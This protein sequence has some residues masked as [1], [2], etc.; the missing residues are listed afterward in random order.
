MKTAATMGNWWLAALSKQ[1]AHSCGIFWQ[2]IKPPRRLASPTIHLVPCNF[3][4][5]P[6]L[7]SPLKGKIFQAVSEILGNMM[8]QLMMIRNCV[9][10]QGAYFEG[11]WGVVVLCTMFLVSSSRNVSIFH[12][13]WLDI[14]WTYLI[15]F[16]RQRVTR[17]VKGLQLIFCTFIMFNHFQIHSPT[18]QIYKCLLS[19]SHCEA[20]KSGSLVNSSRIRAS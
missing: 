14:Y 18:S 11:D 20:N 4:L 6:K 19:W 12:N 10:S 2:N 8:G 16:R 5:F 13:T 15:V 1:R 17:M 9:R 3:W 7:K